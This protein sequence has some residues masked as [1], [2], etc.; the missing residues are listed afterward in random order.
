MLRSDQQIAED[1][2]NMCR[3]VDP[4]NSKCAKLLGTVDVLKA[5]KEKSEDK[6]SDPKIEALEHLERTYEL[7]EGKTQKQLL[8]AELCKAAFAAG[9]YDKAES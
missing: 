2:L 6:A 7:T 9:N 5:V 8:L 4:K 1:L 3:A